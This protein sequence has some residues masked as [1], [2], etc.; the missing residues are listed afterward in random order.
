MVHFTF[1]RLMLFFRGLMFWCVNA[2]VLKNL[3]VYLHTALFPVCSVYININPYFLN[4]ITLYSSHVLQWS[5]HSHMQ[6]IQRYLGTT[7]LYLGSTS[8]PVNLVLVQQ[9]TSWPMP[10]NSRGFWI[11]H[12]AP[13]SVGLLWTSDQLV[14]ET[15]IFHYRCRHLV[16]IHLL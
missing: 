16:Y 15:S 8:L 1:Y 9:P 5:C 12:D 10:S 6:T 7:S 14:A 13:H 4:S 2:S 11:T 3:A